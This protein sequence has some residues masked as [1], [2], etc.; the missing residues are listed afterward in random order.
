MVVNQKKDKIM[1]ESN[2]ISVYVI[3]KDLGGEGEPGWEVWD[4]A[5][6]TVAYVSDSKFDQAEDAAYLAGLFAAAPLLA[7]C[8]GEI[9]RSESMDDVR[10][11]LND[12]KESLAS[13]Q[14]R[15]RIW[16]EPE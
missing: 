16:L 11:W 12:L 13:S 2:L 7:N 5:F 15:K 14:L 8:L 4:L 3:P 6:N 9:V 1:A 10:Y